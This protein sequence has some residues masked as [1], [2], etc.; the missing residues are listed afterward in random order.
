MSM[1]NT[2]S[3][4]LLGVAIAVVMP[5]LPAWWNATKELLQ[6][7]QRNNFGDAATD[8]AWTERAIAHVWGDAWIP[9]TPAEG[10]TLAQ[11]VSFNPEGTGTQIIPFFLDDNDPMK[12]LLQN[13][14]IWGADGFANR[15]WEKPSA[16]TIGDDVWRA[17][18]WKIYQNHPLLEKA[19]GMEYW[20]NV[21]TADTPLEWHVDKDTDAWMHDD[22]L[23]LPLWGAVY[24]GYPHSFRGG[25]LEVMVG[26]VYEEWP[27]HVGGELERIRADY[28]RL[29]LFNASKWHRVTP[30]T[31]NGER[32][33]LAVNLWDQRPTTFDKAAAS[34][35]KEPS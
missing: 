8:L 17:L 32:L 22:R 26:G 25:Y 4:L 29:V 33:A 16:E 23:M 30:I 24:Y 1:S 11:P 31:D 28:N 9:R 20:V 34:A 19:V 6:Q 12:R 7:Q 27:S 13:R 5:R 15:W 18:A 3:K 2:V 14:T 35:E 21:L 10:I